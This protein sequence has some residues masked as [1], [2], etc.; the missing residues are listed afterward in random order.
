MRNTASRWNTERFFRRN[1]VWW[2][3]FALSSWF[4][5][6]GTQARADTKVGSG[7][8][9]T[10]WVLILDNSSSMSAGSVLTTNT[11]TVKLPPADPDRLSVLATLIFRGLLSPDDKLTILAFQSGAVG[12]YRELPPQATSIRDL[13]FD[14]STPFTGPLKRAREILEKSRLSSRR[15]LLFTDGSPSNDDPL[16]G[17]QARALLG[18]EALPPGEISASPS[19]VSK[20]PF[21]VLSLGLSANIAELQQVQKQFLSAL[22]PVEE[23]QTPQEIVTGFTRAIASHLQ[24][25]PLTGQL[26]PGGTYS[27]PVGKYVT[28]I[29]V[30]MAS[31]KKMPVFS[32]QLLDGGRPMPV[33]EEA[34]DNGCEQA[35][36]HTYR[37][38][39]TTHDPE[40]KNRLALRLDR[41]AGQVAFGVILRYDLLAEITAAPSLTRVGEE[42][43]VVSRMV[44]RGRTFSDS[45]FLAADGFSAQL[46]LGDVK[47]P[48]NRRGDGN[49]TARIKAEQLG[50]QPLLARFKNQWL[51]L[52]ASAPLTVEGWLPLALKATP[53]PLPFGHMVGERVAKRRCVSVSLAGSLNADRVPLEAVGVDLPE[54]VRLLSATPLSVRNNAIELCLEAPGC[55]KD[56]SPGPQ[57]R[58]LLRGQHPHYHPDAV[59]LALEFSVDKTPFLVCYARVL[60]A[61]AGALFLL[62]VLYGL[63]SPH[64]FDAAEV[65]RLAKS[66]SA[67]QRTSGRR[68]RDLPGGKRGFYR[69]AAVAFDASGNTP[70]RFKDAAIIV[71]ATGSEPLIIVHGS[72]EHKDP[73]TRKWEALKT[74]LDPSALRRGVVYRS[75]DMYFR[76]G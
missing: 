13:K 41:S 27:F 65:I 38:M 52:T 64:D 37:V 43:E 61:I 56:L 57:S 53:N 40:T 39:R 20:Q 58:I 54:G 48:L 35:P 7:A 18:F 68:L 3:W 14:Q 69:H 15:L 19:V 24:S 49:F 21:E 67:L 59:P 42:F 33:R 55:C 30:S 28:E 76:L 11:G 26:A 5:F 66:E 16:T 10:E 50:P 23:V 22:G 9:P 2:S 74:P 44:W 25:R 47:V 34:G 75:G 12:Q 32:A 8:G 36:C 62:F 1:L 31:V 70:Q 72:V 63:L 17:A 4:G 73:R 51:D 29:L 71:R 6:F 45:D 46:E 60:A